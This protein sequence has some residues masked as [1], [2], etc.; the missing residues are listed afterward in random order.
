MD[1]IRLNEFDL[2]NAL[3]QNPE[4]CIV[5]WLD[6]IDFVMPILSPQLMLDLH[7][8]CDHEY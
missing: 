2:W 5:K 1:L 3:I 8:E 7:Q 4:G 6:E